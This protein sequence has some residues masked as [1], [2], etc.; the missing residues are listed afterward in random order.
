MCRI[1]FQGVG[2]AEKRK[3]EQAMSE[4]ESVVKNLESGDMTLDQSLAAFEKGVSLAR[5]CEEKLTEAKGK[6]EQLIKD[7]EGRAKTAPLEVK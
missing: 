1:I 2:M 3:F 7:S 5:E 6:I 4:L